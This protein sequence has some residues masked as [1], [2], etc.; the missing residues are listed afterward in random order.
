MKKVLMS[1]VALCA[2]AVNVFA[3]EG[4]K[5]GAEITD[6][7]LRNIDGKTVSLS[8]MQDAKGYIVVFTCNHCPYAKAYEDRII[9]LH[10]KFAPE[11][12]PVV[13]INSNDPKAEPQ[14]S[15]ANMKVRA[16]QKKF[17]FVYLF[18]ENQDV[19]KRFGAVRTPHVFLVQ[20]DLNTNKMIVRY[21][22]AIDDNWEDAKATK[23][24]YVAD[25]I[26]SLNAGTPVA[27]QET[28]AIGCTIKWKK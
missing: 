22:G 3:Q 12:Y 10:K 18:D 14:D 23:Q 26:E 9:A 17:P 1:I 2:L 6:F 4:Y 27:V 11:G 21:V 25:A 20:K 19:A 24:Q 8:G 13:A 7:K 16:E 15:Y 5:P 28:K